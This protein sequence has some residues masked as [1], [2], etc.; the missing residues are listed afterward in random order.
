MQ[1]YF[2]QAC[3]FGGRIDEAEAAL[4]AAFEIA[5]ETGEKWYLPELYRLQGEVLLAERPALSSQAEACY[6]R[7]LNLSREQHAK[8]F[9]LRAAMSLARLWAE[10]GE[11]ERAHDLLAPIYGWFTEAFG[12]RDLIEAKALLDVLS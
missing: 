3:L 12:T 7:A 10:R 2:V 4:H 1:S 6:Q 11:R 9:A 8:A 5:D